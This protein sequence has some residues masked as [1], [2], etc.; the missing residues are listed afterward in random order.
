MDERI[1]RRAHSR[2]QVT[3]GHGLLR[4]RTEVEILNLSLTGAAIATAQRLS[5]GGT[6]RLLLR[7]E[8][9]RIDLDATVVRSALRT[10]RNGTAPPAPVYE[11][12]LEFQEML[13]ER[14][15]E[16]ADFL[17]ENALA[18]I[19]G[20]ICDRFPP[21]AGTQ[22]EIEREE[23]FELRS[24]S[25]SGLAVE[26]AVDLDPGREVALDVRLDRPG[27]GF[28]VTG[29]IVYRLPISP[30]RYLLGIES[31]PAALGASAPTYVA[32]TSGS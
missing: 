27:L 7:Q 30:E 8:S 20:R 25:P 24:I 19:G 10:A 6:Y 5:L 15:Q 28:A 21:P 14:G 23:G 17:T 4:V 31:A 1:E 32:I 22:A 9:H 26:T 3:D 18:E 2:R 11:T 13:G 12:A 29:R 16:V